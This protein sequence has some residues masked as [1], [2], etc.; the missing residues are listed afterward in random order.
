MYSRVLCWGN[1]TNS[2]VTMKFAQIHYFLSQ[3]DGGTKDTMSPPVQKLGG[4]V[5]PI[6]SVPATDYRVKTKTPAA[7]N[8]QIAVEQVTS[9]E[10]DDY[11]HYT[12]ASKTK[13]VTQWWWP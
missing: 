6:N 4:H 8:V 9:P 5:P 7:M 13:S 10:I 3:N 12:C 2:N 1:F 11:F